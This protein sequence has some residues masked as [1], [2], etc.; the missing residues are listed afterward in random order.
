MDPK[1]VNIIMHW[2]TLSTVRGLQA[3]LGFTNY[4][5]RFIYI[6]NQ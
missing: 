1:K 4:Y 5:R 2:E 3:F 6:Y